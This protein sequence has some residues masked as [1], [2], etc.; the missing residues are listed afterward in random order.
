MR[1]YRVNEQGHLV[2]GGCDTV[3]LAREYGTPLYA[4]DEGYIV[5]RCREIRNTFTDKYLNTRAAF[6]SKALQTLDVIRIV[7]REGMY[8]DTVSGGEIY[9]AL[10]AGT[11]PSKILF[12]GNNKT[13]GEILYAVRNNIGRFVVDN[14]Y[15]LDMLEKACSE[16]GRVQKIQLRITPGVDSHTHSKINTGRLDSKFGIS[17]EPENRDRI[18][19]KAMKS[20]H[21]DLMGFHFHVG[22]QLQSNEDHLMA[23]EILLDLV[24]E[25]RGNLGL[26]VKELNL[27]GGFGV[28][29]V[30]GEEDTRV[31]DFTEPMMDA[32]RAFCVEEKMAMPV[33]YIEPG[34]WVVANAGITLYT[35][36][37]IKE[38]PGMKTYVAVDGGMPDNPRYIL[39]EAEYEAV[40]ANKAGLPADKTVS[41]V[42]K[43]CESGDIVVEQTNLTG[44]V[45]SGDVLCVFTTGAYNYTMASNYNRLPR[46]AMVLLR[47]GEHR[48]SVRRETWEDLV[49]REL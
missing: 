34:R 15:E 14:E 30:D 8:L 6:A 31:S 32:I 27:G 25:V 29:Y 24:R 22:S 10:K 47:E 13:E 38:I 44:K 28:R 45:E 18:I 39:Y 26:E 41:I 2:F 49:A 21:L 20:E 16:L 5:E 12:H 40:V 3:E 9:A 4:V 19:R 17:L 23:L 43:C 37:S 1:E 46:P 36:G 48:L 7:T 33:I 35:V 11:D 42:G